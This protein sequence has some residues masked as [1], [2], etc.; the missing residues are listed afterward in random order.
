MDKNLLYIRL[1]KFGNKTEVED[2]FGYLENKQLTDNILLRI[3]KNQII[4]VQGIIYY[5]GDNLIYNGALYLKNVPDRFIYECKQG[6]ILR[7]ELKQRNGVN[8]YL[9]F[10]LSGFNASFSRAISLLE[11]TQSDKDFFN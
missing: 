2:F 1:S 4:K 10:S 3:D 9:K 7:I 5:Q 6:N 8:R 11:N